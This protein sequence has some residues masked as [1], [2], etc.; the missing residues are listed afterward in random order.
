[1]GSHDAGLGAFTGLTD[2]VRQ[3]TAAFAEMD[4]EMVNVQKYTG[5]TKK[6]VVAM[7][8]DFKRMN[9]RTAREELNQ[10]A[11][12]AG[13]LGITATSDIE[14]FVDAADKINV[15]LGDDLGE[16]AVD[17]IGKL[18]MMFGEDKKKDCVGRCFPRAPPSMSWHKA[19]QHLRDTLSISRHAC[20][21]W[22][23][24]RD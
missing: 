11:G 22:V 10:L 2:T 19:R 4:Q 18:A 5:Q 16:K 1:M 13:R 21:E 24:R 23:S 20:R 15:A 17:Q 7:N 8:E 9:T 14:E 12:S 3:T 6:E